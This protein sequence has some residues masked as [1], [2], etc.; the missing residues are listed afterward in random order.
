M[1]KTEVHK[2]FKQGKGTVIAEALR[3]YFAERIA[4]RKIKPL[5]FY[6]P[7]QENK[8]GQKDIIAVAQEIFS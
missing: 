5:E 1:T 4:E 6:K 8:N 7:N 2:A 3:S